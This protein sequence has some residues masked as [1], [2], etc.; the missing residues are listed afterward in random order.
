[1]LAGMAG[2]SAK[3]AEGR[4]DATLA[5]TPEHWREIHLSRERGASWSAPVLWRF[6]LTNP[7]PQI[8]QC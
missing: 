6:P 4:C 1:M 8:R 3:A 7:F 5:R 2:D